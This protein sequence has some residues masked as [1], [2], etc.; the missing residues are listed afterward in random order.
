MAE[1]IGI[2]LPHLWAF[3]VSAFVVVHSDRHDPTAFDQYS[4][5]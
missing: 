1:A 5:S 3:L 2:L 4:K